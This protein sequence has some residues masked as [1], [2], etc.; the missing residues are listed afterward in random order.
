MKDLYL[1]AA[2]VGDAGPSAKFLLQQIKPMSD[3]RLTGNCLLGSRPI[4]S[5][6]GAFGGSPHLQLLRQLL[7]NVFSTPKGHRATP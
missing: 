7:T 3:L 1:W 6:D 5:F 4:L 2:H